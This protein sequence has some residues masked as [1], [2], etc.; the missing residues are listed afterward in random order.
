[1]PNE[2]L[3]VDSFVNIRSLLDNNGSSE[4]EAELNRNTVTKRNKMI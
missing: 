3:L 4:G 1:M 2:R